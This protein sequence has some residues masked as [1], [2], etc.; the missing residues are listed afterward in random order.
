MLGKDG[1]CERLDLAVPDDAH[2]GALEAEIEPADPGEQASDPHVIVRSARVGR[3]HCIFGK[4][5]GN[6]RKRERRRC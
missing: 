2:A 1:R 5:F 3:R 4:D 6:I